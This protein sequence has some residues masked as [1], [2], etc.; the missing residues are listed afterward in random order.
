M[1]ERT[2]TT[3]VIPREVAAHV[4]WNERQGGYPAG[5]FTTKLLEL[6]AFADFVNA[7]RLEAAWPEYGA[8]LRMLGEPGGVEKLRAVAG[9]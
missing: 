7:A 1:N 2:T 3:L 9:D 5:S 8:A 6:W 4:L